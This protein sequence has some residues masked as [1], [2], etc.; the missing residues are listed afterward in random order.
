LR[1]GPWLLRLLV[2][3][4]ARA[5]KEGTVAVDQRLGLLLSILRLLLLCLE[6]LGLI[7]VPALFIRIR[8]HEDL[9]LIFREKGLRVGHLRL[10]LLLLRLLLRLL[11]L[12]LLLKAIMIRGSICGSAVQRLDR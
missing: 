1:L 7:G 3:V 4:T 6:V 2:L 12:L 9:L 10:L 11:L 5:I 8:G